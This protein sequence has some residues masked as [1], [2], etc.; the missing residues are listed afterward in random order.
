MGLLAN[1]E[2]FSLSLEI[3]RFLRPK[4][5]NPELEIDHNWGDWH[6]FETHTQIRVY[7]FEGAPNVLPKI[8]LDMIAYLEIIR[9]MCESNHL[10]LRSIGKQSFLPGYLSFGDFVVK[11]TKCYEI[12]GKKMK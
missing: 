9:Q 4:D 5:F 1:D 12:I 11:N 2:V 3:R 7:G 8:I 10:Y 6:S